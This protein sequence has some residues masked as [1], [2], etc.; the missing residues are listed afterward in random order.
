MLFWP[1]FLPQSANHVCRRA[2]VLFIVMSNTYCLVFFVLLVFVLCIVYPLFPGFDSFILFCSYP[3]SLY[4]LCEGNT[5]FSIVTGYF[6][7]YTIYI[8]YI[9][10]NLGRG[11]VGAMVFFFSFRI[12][13]S[14]NTRVR[15]FIFFVALSSKFFSRI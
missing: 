1:L 2:H 12:F 10:L 3:L 5:G 6:C 11:G 7:Q 14:D 13:F 8:A 15:I 9:L 4:G